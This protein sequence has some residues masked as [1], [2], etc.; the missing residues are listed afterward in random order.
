MRSIDANIP[1]RILLRDDP[2]QEVVARD[3]LATPVMLIPT[4]VLEIVFIL[5]GK[6]W[7][8]EEI[9]DGLS[10]IINMETVFVREEE[11]LRLVLAHYRTAG[12]FADM[13]NVALSV[14]ADSFVTF[15]G[16]IRRFMPNGMIP[17]E[18][19]PAQA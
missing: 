5:P 3:V 1:L 11:A 18:T 4:V 16:R 12:A 15:D 7:N 9:S 17:V 19:L 6:G 2:F 8:R 13:F 10:I 14:D